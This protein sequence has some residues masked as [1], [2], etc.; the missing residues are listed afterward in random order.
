MCWKFCIGSRFIARSQC[1]QCHSFSESSSR[2]PRYEPNTLTMK[3]VKMIHQSSSNQNIPHIHHI[4]IFSFPF[5]NCNKPSILFTYLISYKKSSPYTELR[6]FCS[7][8]KVHMITFIGAVTHRE[9]KVP[10]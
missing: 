3:A 1:G 9:L 6:S 2:S 4:I 7:L 10:T 8:L 5:K